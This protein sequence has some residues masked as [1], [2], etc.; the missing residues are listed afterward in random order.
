MKRIGFWLCI[1]GAL[2]WIAE[3]WEAILDA[4]I[5]WMAPGL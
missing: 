2:M 3:R 1:V 5:T 4:I